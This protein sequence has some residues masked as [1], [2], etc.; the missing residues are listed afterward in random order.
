MAGIGLASFATVGAGLATPSSAQAG[1][2]WDRVAECESSGNWS[3][4]TGNGFYGGLQFSYSTWQAFGGQRYAPTADRATKAQQITVAKKVLQ[5]QG[6]GAWPHCSRVAGL[7]RANGGAV[8]AGSTATAASR[9]TAR[10]A[11]AVRAS[12]TSLAAGALVV[13]GIRGPKTNAAIERWVGGSVNGSLS[14]SDVQRLQRKVGSAPDGVIGPKTV[15]ALQT[16]IGAKRN[17]ARHLDRETVR[18]LQRYLNAH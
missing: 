10:R 12:R 3:I 14:R 18:T 7:T 16:K 13:D 17:G 4:N 1:T 6:P 5:V 8:N 2:V 11:P 15:R 9:S